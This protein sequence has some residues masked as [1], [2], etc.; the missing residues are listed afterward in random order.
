M[1]ATGLIALAVWLLGAAGCARLGPLSPL[2]PLER[3][4]LYHPAEYPIGDWFPEDLEYEDA[5]F[6]AADNVRLHGWYAPHDEPR[7]VALCL[8][9]NA[10][11]ITHRAAM[12]RTLNGLGLSTLVFDYRG[13]GRSQGKPSEQGILQDARAARAWLAERAGVAERDV[14]LIGGSL[15][16]G[17][18]V[19]LAA[20]DGARGLVLS[21]TFTSLPDVG[22]HHLPLLPTGLLMTNRLDSLSLIKQYHG[23]LLQYHGEAD[24]VVPYELGRELFDAAPGPKRFVS[25][26]GAGHNDDMSAE[27]FA[28]LDAFLDSLPPEEQPTAG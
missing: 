9:G 12:L 11:N 26:E 27:F 18:A 10:G 19:D 8:H 3:A 13:Y 20:R 17:V 6:R 28:S 4:A 15:G 23:P 16:G 24:T 2:A 5:W 14:V 21:S 25:Q 1:R 7:G 22:A